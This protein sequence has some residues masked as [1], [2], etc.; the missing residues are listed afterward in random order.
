MKKKPK[1]DIVFNILQQ[2]L[3]NS[4][5]RSYKRLNPSLRSTLDNCIEADLPFQP[6]TFSR[7]YSEMRGHWW[8][9]DGAGSAAGEHYYA[10]ACHCNHASAQQSFEQYA[11]RPGVLWEED[12]GTP[13][14]LHV[15]SEFTWRSEH[16]TV[17]SMRSD[18][19]VACSYKGGR[20][21]VHGLKPGAV[22][23]EAGY[24]LI[25][26]VKKEGKSTLLT[27]V[28][29]PAGFDSREIKRRVTI[30]YAD[31]IEFRR[32]AKARV[33]AVLEKI[34]KC[35]P[36]SDAIALSKEINAEHFR[37]FE[38]E[39]INRAFSKRKGL[40]AQKEKIIEW[41]AGGYGAWLGSDS[42][43]LR[44][45]NGYVECSNG[46]AVDADAA[47]VV[48]PVLLQHR[49]TSARLNIP[50]DGHI[51]SSVD[52]SGVQIGCTLIPWEEIDRIA[53]ML[54]AA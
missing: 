34:A 8:F 7:I 10:T 54:K 32:T 47:K 35:E 50:L 1:S 49:N 20:D 17:T 19:L 33:K 40:I 27:V 44:L 48:L 3:A 28:Q 12:I 53:P 5:E 21:S 2:M 13:S 41:R 45:R 18:S 37:H 23:H 24:H 6:D 51:V 25:T 29:T 15:G 30:K 4:P 22:I 43:L 16:L 11:G 42:I 38:L 14:R 52:K 46:N 36:S 9:G 31:I 26:A 39:E